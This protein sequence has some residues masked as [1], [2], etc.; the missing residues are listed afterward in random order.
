MF[1]APIVALLAIALLP[2]WPVA[3]VLLGVVRIL[4]WPV[5][6]L[7]SRAGATWARNWADRM[8]IWFAYTI[9]PW[10]YFDPPE[11]RRRMH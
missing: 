4:F 6:R 7:A 5:E 2:F 10:K 1:A 11:K 3:I 9:R 8:A